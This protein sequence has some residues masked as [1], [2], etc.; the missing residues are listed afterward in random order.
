MIDWLQFKL[1]VV[2]ALV[3]KEFCFQRKGNYKM[4]K[5]GAFIATLCCVV[6]GICAMVTEPSF[7]ENP[8]TY[9]YKTIYGSVITKTFNERV[10]S[11]IYTGITG[12]SYS[13]SG[14]RTI[15]I[16]VSLPKPYDVISLS[17]NLGKVSGSASVHVTGLNKKYKYKVYVKKTIQCKPY[18][19]KKRLRHKKGAKWEIWSRGIIPVGDDVVKPYAKRVT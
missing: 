9:E 10:D 2:F 8:G 5:I 12:F 19:V 13:P 3:L 15:S 4:N 7:A 1:F 18:I 14:G 17:T 11:Y 6:V 16:S